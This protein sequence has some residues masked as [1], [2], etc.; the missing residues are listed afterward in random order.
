VIRAQLDRL[1]TVIGLP[2]VRLG[3]VPLGGQLDTTPQ[4]SFVL[5]DDVAKVETFV[6]S[7]PIPGDGAASYASIMV[8]LWAAAAEGDEA[9]RVIIRAADELR[10]SSSFPSR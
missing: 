3:V 1:Q 9:R 8:R 6:G 4:N 5:Y 7:P 2:N 10:R